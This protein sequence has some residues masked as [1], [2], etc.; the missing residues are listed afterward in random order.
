MLE[1]SDN[2]MKLLEEDQSTILEVIGEQNA[3]CLKCFKF[4][5]SNSSTPINANP[6]NMKQQFTHTPST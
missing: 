5:L 1:G 2:P 6:S 4:I 3:D